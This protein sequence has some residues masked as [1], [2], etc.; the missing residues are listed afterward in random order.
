MSEFRR[1]LM[2]QVASDPNALPAGCVRLEFLE[3]TGEQLIDTGYVPNFH[4]KTKVVAQF[5]TLDSCIM[6]VFYG[7]TGYDIAAYDVAGYYSVSGKWFLRAFTTGSTNMANWGGETSNFHT[8]ETDAESCM[9]AVD[10]VSEKRK[11]D[12]VPP[13]F[14]GT[15]HLFGRLESRLGIFQ[16]KGKCRVKSAVFSEGDKVVANLIPILAPQGV[17]CMFDTVTKKFHYNKGTGHFLHP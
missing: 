16:F 2:A 11:R 8:F 3:S 9:V 15:I 7:Q 12:N 14:V 17:P 6:G 4:T 13:T 1:R 10:S 5:L